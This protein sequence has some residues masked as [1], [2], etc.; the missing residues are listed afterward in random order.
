MGSF[1]SMVLLLPSSPQHWFMLPI[2][3]A[4]RVDGDYLP[5]F[6]ANLVAKKLYN[7]VD[8]LAGVT[9]DEGAMTTRGEFAH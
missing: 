6:P 2:I 5:D 8:L 3:F 7:E 1:C 9:K 4:P